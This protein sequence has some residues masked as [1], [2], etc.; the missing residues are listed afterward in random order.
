MSY[1]QNEQ[2]AAE[3]LRYS[4]QQRQACE[5]VRELLAGGGIDAAYRVQQINTDYAQ[6]QGCRLVGRKIGLT[7]K[8]VQTQLGVDQ[9]DFGALFADMAVCEG[10][11]I[12]M[13]R[14]MQPKIEGEVALVLE[15][16]LAMDNP[17]IADVISASAYVLPALEIVDSR[18]ANWDIRIEDTVAD[19]ASSG[20]FVLGGTPKLLN[21]V[22]LKACGMSL[23]RRGEPVSTGA[24]QACLGHPLSAAVWLAKTMSRLEQPLRTGDIILTGALGPM[25]PVQAGDVFDCEISGLG[26][27]RASFAKEGV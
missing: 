19:N 2:R 15:S 16:D 25:V 11:E 12:A 8:V 24:G 5:P 14:L 6:Q 1:T 3:A 10:E 18:V 9:P 4:Q 22:D 21:Q 23:F 26:S 7:S 27:V 17:T 20:L 13:S